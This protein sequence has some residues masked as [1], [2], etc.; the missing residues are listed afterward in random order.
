MNPSKTVFLKK[1]GMKIGF[2]AIG[3][4]YAAV[5]AKIVMQK[6]GVE[7]G[8][9]NAAGDLLCWGQPLADEPWTVKI[10]DP[11][12]PR[13]A[14][15]EFDIPPGSVVTSGGYEKYALVNGK[16]YSHIIDPR[17]GMPVE[18]LKSVSII[19]PNPELGDALATAVTVLGQEQG[20]AL[21]DQLAGVECLIVN[22]D[23]ELINSAYSAS[24]AA[25][26][27]NVPRRRN[28]N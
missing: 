11:E 12:N 20:L 15:A 2:G 1:E 9:V 3:K 19:C 8:L 16:K 17:T 27:N 18:G 25:I 4:G 21:I 22:N 13:R 14:L 24:T 28:A 5:R 6:M 23:N 26:A 7:S 10:S